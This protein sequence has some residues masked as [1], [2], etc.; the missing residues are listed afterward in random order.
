M[1]VREGDELWET[2]IDMLY[3]TLKAKILISRA[4]NA[5]RLG[6]ELNN[7]FLLTLIFSFKV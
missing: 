7:V 1:L 4:L 2:I 5:T 3:K 6:P